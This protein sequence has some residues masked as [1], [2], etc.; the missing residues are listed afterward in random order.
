MGVKEKNPGQDAAKIQPPTSRKIFPSNKSAEKESAF[1]DICKICLGKFRVSS[2]KFR[3]AG[4]RARQSWV[5]T[6]HLP[7]LITRPGFGLN[8]HGGPPHVTFHD[9]YQ[10]ALIKVIFEEEWWAVPTLHFFPGARL[11][12]PAT[13]V[14]PSC[15]QTSRGGVSPPVER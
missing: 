12:V 10:V 3:G 1:V 11:A 13:E 9:L 4:L 6:A 15:R 14:L 8:G 5:R 7:R 2:F